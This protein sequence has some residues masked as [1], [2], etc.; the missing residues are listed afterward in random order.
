MHFVIYCIFELENS[1]MW[2]GSNGMYLLN[3]YVHFQNHDGCPT[4]MPME[5]YAWT[6]LTIEPADASF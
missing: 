6:I 5:Q 4:D 2:I 3:Y 1:I